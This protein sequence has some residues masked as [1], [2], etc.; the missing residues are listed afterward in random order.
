[1]DDVRAWRWL[2]MVIDLGGLTAAA[3]RVHRSPSTIS[4]AIKTL[5]DRIGVPL[6]TYRGRNLILTEA[7]R[8]LTE[9]M[10]PVLRDL[11]EATGL[12]T[13]IRA[14]VEPLLRVAIDQ[15]VPQEQVCGLLQ[16]LAD[17]Y[18]ATRVELYET[19]LGGG[20]LRLLSGEVDAYL[21]SQEVTHH[22]GRAA[23]YV[24][25]VAMAAKTHPLAQAQRSPLD[26][27]E[28]RRYRQIV[29]RDS[30]PQRLA[31][32]SW[33]AAEQR[34][35]VDHLHTAVGLVR[36]GLGFSWLPSFVL[37]QEP[38][39][40]AL[41]LPEHMAETLPLALYARPGFSSGPAGRLIQD[42]VAQAINGL[43]MP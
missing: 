18:P 20:P 2:I 24:T 8:A 29:I 26:E 21:G 40:T 1:M 17:A 41:S 16:Q 42:I 28:L 11:D 23:G 19:V 39:L 12:V 4:H 31:R 32:G 9:R 10:R 36:A 22:A 30:A 5:E 27:A 3:A 6:V 38:G 13:Q 35:T 33:L 15:I 14:G 34:Y 37:S 43:S 7:G 25:L